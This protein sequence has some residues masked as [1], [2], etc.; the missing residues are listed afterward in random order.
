[1]PEYTKDIL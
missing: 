1:V